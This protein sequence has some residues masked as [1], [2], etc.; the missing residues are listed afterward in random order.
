M[1]FRGVFTRLAVLALGLASA[2]DLEVAAALANAAAGLVVRR[3]GV[4]TVSPE[5]LLAALEE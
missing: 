3:I 1:S 2:A 5:E 4:A